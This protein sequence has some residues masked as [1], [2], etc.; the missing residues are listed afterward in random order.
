MDSRPHVSQV[1]V[2]I[3]C[4]SESRRKERNITATVPSTNNRYG[5]M[6]LLPIG[7]SQRTLRER[8]GVPRQEPSSSV[9]K[10]LLQQR[11]LR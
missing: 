4:Y 7:T 6:V 9:M 11:V 10:T 3:L 5:R 1:T 2:D 8:D